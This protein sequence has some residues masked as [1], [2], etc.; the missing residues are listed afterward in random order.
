MHHA[1]GRVAECV[2]NGSRRSV[3][4][5]PEIYPHVNEMTSPADAI[6]T[7]ETK[8]DSQINEDAE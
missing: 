6:S 1:R 3:S 5:E 7:T 8:E 4:T 2:F